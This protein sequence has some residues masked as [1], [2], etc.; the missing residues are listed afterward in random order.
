ILRVQR[1][2]QTYSTN[3]PALPER[4]RPFA[5][6][7]SPKLGCQLPDLRVARL[8]QFKSRLAIRLPAAK[9]DGRSASREFDN[10]SKRRS[11]HVVLVKIKDQHAITHAVRQ[12]QVAVA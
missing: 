1:R 8:R 5:A 11:R 2:G 10:F 4:A 9:N 7:I 3:D 6:A 12:N